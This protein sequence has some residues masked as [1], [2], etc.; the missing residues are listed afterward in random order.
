MFVGD[1]ILGQVYCYYH[2]TLSQS[3]SPCNDFVLTVLWSG[4]HL[5][6]RP[7][8]QIGVVCNVSP[9]T[10]ADNTM[11]IIDIHHHH[12]YHCQNIQIQSE[13]LSWTTAVKKDIFLLLKSWVPGSN[14][15]FPT[16]EL[17]VNPLEGLKWPRSHCSIIQLLTHGAEPWI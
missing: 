13:E 7:R 10:L 11:I 4:L 16:K 3:S 14:W 5:R 1:Y 6:F 9:P 12:P 17:N 15:N 2:C 8:G